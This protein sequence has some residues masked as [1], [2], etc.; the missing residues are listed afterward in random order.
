MAR[1]AL[2]HRA[3]AVRRQLPAE[4]VTFQPPSGVKSSC[5]TAAVTPMSTHGASAATNRLPRASS[6]AAIRAGWFQRCRNLTPRRA[7]HNAFAAE[8]DFGPGLIARKRDELRHESLASLARGERDDLPPD[9]YV[10]RLRT[11]RA[12]DAD[13]HAGCRCVHHAQSNVAFETGACRIVLDL[14][15]ALVGHAMADG[16]RRFCAQGPIGSASAIANTRTSDSPTCRKGVC[17]RRN[18]LCS[19]IARCLIGTT[20]HQTQRGR[21]DCHRAHQR[22]HHTP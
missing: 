16:A 19:V 9:H 12:R 6:P 3:G 4:V 13:L 21:H 22:P 15:R 8:E 17:Y 1:K 2:K 10:K 5:A 11:T 7:T 18:V 20:L 14:P